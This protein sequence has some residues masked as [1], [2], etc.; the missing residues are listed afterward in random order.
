MIEF[1]STKITIKKE[2]LN[3]LFRKKGRKTLKVSLKTPNGNIFGINYK[4]NQLWISIKLI[5]CKVSARVIG[6]QRKQESLVHTSAA[7]VKFFIFL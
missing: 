5:K 4:G 1:I 2:K 7:K 6:N 3:K